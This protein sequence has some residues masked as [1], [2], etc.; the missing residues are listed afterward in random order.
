LVL[1]HGCVWHPWGTTVTAM[2]GTTIDHFSFPL[3]FLGSRI[4][5]KGAQKMKDNEKKWSESSRL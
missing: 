4:A 3:S 1:M 2:A 5:I